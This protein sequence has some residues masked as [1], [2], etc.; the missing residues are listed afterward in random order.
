[1]LAEEQITK[2]QNAFKR[3]HAVLYLNEN[4]KDGYILANVKSFSEP[5]LIQIK[6]DQ[7]GTKLVNQQFIHAQRFS[8][9]DFD[10]NLNYRTHN[11]I[12]DTQRKKLKVK[13]ERDFRIKVTET[14]SLVVN[15]ESDLMSA[16]LNLVNAILFLQIH[17]HDFVAHQDPLIQADLEL[18]KE[19]DAVEHAAAVYREQKAHNVSHKKTKKSSLP[20]AHGQVV[21]GFS[22]TA[23]TPREIRYAKER[24]ARAKKAAFLKAHPEIVAKRKKAAAYRKAHQK[25][26]IKGKKVATAGRL[27][28]PKA[29]Y[30]NVMKKVGG[31]L[32][33]QVNGQTDFLICNQPNKSK[34]Y[35]LA[36]KKHVRI[37]RETQISIK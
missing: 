29:Y 13:L 33:P 6:S 9:N 14:G 35:Q 3:Y 1:M 10:W 17:G 5:L 25:F 30:Q 2:L 15:A 20:K 37:I 31:K 4:T 18:E 21:A 22:S 7:Q 8:G 12:P 36:I 23:G 32:Q 26:S 11:A 19:Q 16:Y 27:S 28:M 24:R 34:N